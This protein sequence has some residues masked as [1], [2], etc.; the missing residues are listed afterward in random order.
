ML[1]ESALLQDDRY[2]RTREEL[3]Q[4]SYLEGSEGGGPGQPTHGFKVTFCH[5]LCLRA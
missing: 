5:A 2:G 3:L 1:E 4:E